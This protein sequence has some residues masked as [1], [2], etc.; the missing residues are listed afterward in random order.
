MTDPEPHGGTWVTLPD[1]SEDCIWPEPRT[2]G[3]WCSWDANGEKGPGWTLGGT[4]PPSSS[5]DYGTLAAQFEAAR[6]SAAKAVF[7]EV[8]LWAHSG[9]PEV[10]DG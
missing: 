2:F 8:M 6:W 5:W 7:E 9:L 4:T 3:I 1:G 10:T